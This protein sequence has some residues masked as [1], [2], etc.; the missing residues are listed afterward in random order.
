MNKK[1]TSICM[2]STDVSEQTG[3]HLLVCTLMIGVVVYVR[4]VRTS[5]NYIH[6]IPGHVQE[7]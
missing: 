6:D 1:T 5:Q 7:N 3:V 2:H 4:L